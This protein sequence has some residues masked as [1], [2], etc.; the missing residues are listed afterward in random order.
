MYSLHFS[1][2]RRKIKM[3]LTAMSVRCV[4]RNQQ[5]PHTVGLPLSAQLSCLALQEDLKS[6]QIALF[7]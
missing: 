3:L 4:H 1:F 6:I 7:A 2:L 5:R